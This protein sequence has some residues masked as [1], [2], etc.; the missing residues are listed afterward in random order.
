MASFESPISNKKFQGQPMRHLD[1]P[2]ESDTP[3]GPPMGGGKFSP[4]VTHRYGAPMN[5]QEMLEFQQRVEASNNSDFNLSEVERD[6]KRSREDKI[7]GHNRLNDGAKKRI[8][9]LVGITRGT[10]VAEIEGNIYSF[11][12]LKSKEMR[13]VWMSCAEFDGTVQFP[14]ELRRQLLA[15][16]L[17]QVAG[18]ELAQFVGSDLLEDKL[19]FIDD[20]DDLLLVRLYDEYLI[21]VRETKDRYTI[22]TEADVKE[23]VED[24]KK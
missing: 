14:Y 15:R 10:R 9:M 4:S 1:I 3:Q 5:E 19:S 12:T 24:L 8:D 7:R 18:V 2:D 23:V 11:K 16:S 20:A 17:T 22:K 6:V 21:M 13:E